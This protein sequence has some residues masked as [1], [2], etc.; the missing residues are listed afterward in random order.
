MSD[1]IFLIGLMGVGKTTVGRLVAQQL[2]YQFKDSDHEIEQRTGASI[3]LIFELEGEAGFRNRETNMVD[4]LTQENNI[5]LATGGGVILNAD[6]RRYLRER[7][8]VIYLYADIDTLI[9]R[10]QHSKNRPLLQTENPRAKLEE[11]MQQRQAL[12]EETAHHRIKTGAEPVKAVVNKILQE[13]N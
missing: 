10:T 9:E 6:N 2:H 13:I 4:E 7:G 5:V 8:K 3:P 11:L 12:Y 1:N